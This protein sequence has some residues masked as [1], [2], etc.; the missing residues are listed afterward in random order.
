MNEF[1]QVPISKLQIPLDVGC[2]GLARILKIWIVQN[3]S[4]QKYKYSELTLRNCVVSVQQI[5]KW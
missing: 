5:K 1:G 2:L 3:Q 4:E